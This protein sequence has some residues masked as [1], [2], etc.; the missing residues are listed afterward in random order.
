MRTPSLIYGN[1]KIPFF[2]DAPNDGKEYVRKNRSWS[3]ASTEDYK[4]N[5]HSPE[6]VVDILD[7][8]SGFLV[9]VDGTGGVS[10][11]LAAGDVK[12]T[13][14]NENGETTPADVP[15]FNV[16]SD[17][18]Y[19]V[20]TW[21][22]VDGA[23]GYRVYYGGNYQEVLTAEID[24]LLFSGSAGTL[25]TENTAVIYQSA[26]QIDKDDT[27]QYTGEGIDIE[28][29]VD[30]LDSTKKIINILKQQSDWNEADTE[31]PNYIANKPTIP[32]A[33]AQPFQALIKKDVEAGTA[34]E[35]Y[36][37][38]DC[39]ENLTVD[40]VTVFCDDGTLTGCSIEING[41]AINWTGPV[42]TF[43]ISTTKTRISAVSS[44]TATST[45]GIIFYYTTG[46]TGTP[47]A[48]WVQLNFHKT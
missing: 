32:A 41:S 21:D 29:S 3:E 20:I 33:G 37:I 15:A 19:A 13:A 4:W 17:S 28:T 1:I 42:S 9:D 43:T 35:E 36:L 23:T 8:P 12:V 7:V 14:I 24:Y 38:I 46:Y 39:L 22:E 10:Q 45:N 31:S 48:V 26:F 34:G 40:S 27:V 18:T 5:I 2:S 47:T 44:N 30:L 11:A 16:L 25:P 6:Q